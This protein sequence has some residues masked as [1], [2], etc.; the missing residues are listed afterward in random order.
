MPWTIDWNVAGG[1]QHEAFPELHYARICAADHYTNSLALHVTGY[2][3]K[4]DAHL[5][6][7]APDLLALAKQYASECT[8]CDGKGVITKQY[9]GDGYGDRCAALADAEQS[10]EDCADIRKIIDAAEGRS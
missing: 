8:G 3:T 4:A 1:G 6:R 2:M 9:G 10:C 7:S 5:L